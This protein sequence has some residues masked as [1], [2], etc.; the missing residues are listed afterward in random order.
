MRARRRTAL[1]ILAAL[2]M[3]LCFPGRAA[4]EGAEDEALR[5]VRQMSLEEKASMVFMVT[6]E[7]LTGADVVTAAGEMT[8]TALEGCPVGGLIYF[9]QNLENPAQTTTMLQ[10]LQEMA[11]EITGY[12]LILA[13]DEEGGTVTRIA[14]N[15]QFGVENVGNMA[16]LTYSE[17]AEGAFNAGASI[18]AYLKACGFNVDLAPVADVL[19][20]PDNTLL[21]DRSFGRTGALVAMMDSAFLKGL[22]TAGIAGTL[23]H[24]PGHGG[25]AEDSHTGLAVNYAGR[26]ELRETEWLPYAQCIA[27]GAQIVMVGHIAVPEI[28]GDMTPASLSGTLIDG[29]LRGEMGFDGLV[30]TDALN[31]GAVTETYGSAA[32]AAEALRAGADMLLMPADFPAARQGVIDA[33]RS[34]SLPEERLN[35]AAARILRFRM[36]LLD[37]M[38]KEQIPAGTETVEESTSAEEEIVITEAETS[39]G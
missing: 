6:P 4:A 31:M 29:V 26:E 30:I 1:L 14:Q 5:T 11:V 32:A 10:S 7:A 3:I 34:G 18:G 22:K 35:E 16:D 9:S 13:L 17:G 38:K 28:T 2:Q 8:R 21:Q 23:K 25:A 27:E 33:V 37:Q 15:P 20:N 39:E 36:G 19:T 24:F 12:P